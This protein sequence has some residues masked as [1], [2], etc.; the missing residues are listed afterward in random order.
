MKGV[1]VSC[2]ADLVITKFG[3]DRWRNALAKA[4][5]DRNMIVLATSDLDDAAVLKVVDAVCA[6]LDLTRQQAADAFGEHWVCTFAPRTYKAFY[7]KNAREFLL[8]MDG[9]HDQT[10][11]TMPNAHPPRFSYAWEDDKNLVM[12]YSSGRGLMDFFVGL[13]RGVGKYYKE[14]LALDRIGPNKLRITFP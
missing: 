11:R 9:V 6:E 2:L 14:T 1:I 12:T 13:V 10:T 5:L 3:K 7:K 4:G 8:A